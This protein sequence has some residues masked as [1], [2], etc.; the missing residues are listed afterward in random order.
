M[1]A[2]L[3]RNERIN[4]ARASI[5]EA[6]RELQT[7]PDSGRQRTYIIAR[8]RKH[9]HKA[10]GWLTR[11]LHRNHPTRKPDSEAARLEQQIDDLWPDPNRTF[12]KK[13][14]KWE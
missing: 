10:S 13:T 11:L 4:R 14:E 6:R 1:P 7:L 3:S 2:P 12:N 8:A 9:L 5:Q